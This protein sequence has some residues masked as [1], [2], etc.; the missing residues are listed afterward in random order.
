MVTKAGQ[1]GLE[2]DSGS[3][4]KMVKQKKKPAV[5]ESIYIVD[6]PN[7]LKQQAM[8]QAMVD[9]RKAAVRE[10][11]ARLQAQKQQRIPVNGVPLTKREIK[12]REKILE[13]IKQNMVTS[14]IIGSRS[15]NNMML[16]NEVD[17]PIPEG[18][19]SYGWHTQ[20]FT[21]QDLTNAYRYFP[22][23]IPKNI[24]DEMQKASDAYF[25]KKRRELLGLPNPGK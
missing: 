4:I 20:G 7:Y 22:S 1:M 15:E 13:K 6:D 17:I 14:N 11:A 25:E 8:S 24:Q 5:L 16:P 10:G 9:N 12:E 2:S 23:T 21:P 19:M 18:Q 3:T